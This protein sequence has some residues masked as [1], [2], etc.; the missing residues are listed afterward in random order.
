M[1][2]AVLVIGQCRPWLSSIWVVTIVCVQLTEID[3]LCSLAFH[4][5]LSRSATSYSYPTTL[6]F[7]SNS[8][9]DQRPPR[10]HSQKSSLVI[11]IL[12][13]LNSHRDP[14]W[15]VSRVF[16]KRSCGCCQVLMVLPVILHW[17][18]LAFSQIS[19]SRWWQMNVTPVSG[20]FRI[21]Y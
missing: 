18:N 9:Q 13:C 2:T 15:S 12:V 8:H 20:K 3:Q 7:V 10:N 11:M 14:S 1:S 16:K 21:R 17:V 4:R 5:L 19:I 6:T